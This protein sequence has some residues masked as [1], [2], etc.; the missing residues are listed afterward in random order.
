M[1]AGVL[2]FLKNKTQH[3]KQKKVG[4]INEKTV[5]YKPAKERRNES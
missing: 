1:K 5:G 2:F 4:Y 3:Y